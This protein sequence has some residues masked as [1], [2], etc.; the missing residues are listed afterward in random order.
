MLKGLI[1]AMAAI[2][3]FSSVIL[4][5]NGFNNKIVKAVFL[6]LGIIVPASFFGVLLAGAEADADADF[7][8]LSEIPWWG[9]LIMAIIDVIILLSIVFIEGRPLESIKDEKGKLIATVGGKVGAILISF[10]LTGILVG[11]IV[12]FFV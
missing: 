12:S 3:L 1:T 9:Y 5:L 7:D 2:S 10:F 6:V 11:G 8:M 4:G